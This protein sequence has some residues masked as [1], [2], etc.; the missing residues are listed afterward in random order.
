MNR[1]CITCNIDINEKNYLKDRTVC[2]SCYNKNRT[3][4]NDNTLIQNEQPKFDKISNNNVNNPSVLTY[5]N[6]AYVII[7]LRNVGKT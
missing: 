6:H 5:E 4:N 1:I 2:N 7:G 3:K